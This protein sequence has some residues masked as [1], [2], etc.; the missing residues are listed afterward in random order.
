MKYDFC[1]IGAGLAGLS[2][3]KELSSL[4]NT[5]ILVID[6]LGIGKGASGSPIGLANPATGRYATKSWKAE[7]SLNLL[8]ENLEK[9]SS[10]STEKIFSKSGIV[11]PAMDSKIA[12][13][14]KENVETSDWSDGSCKWL[15]EKE[16]HN[17][18]P[19][20]FCIDGGVW[21]PSGMTV[22]IPKYLDALAS[23]LKVSGVDFIE[24]INFDLRK[25]NNAWFLDLKSTNEIEANHIVITA[26]IKSTR[27][28]FWKDLPLHPVKGQV[29]VFKTEQ[30]FPYRSAISALGYFAG[31]DP[32]TFV[33][34]S[35]YEHKFANEETDRKG[36]SYIEDRMLRVMPYM[37][38]KYKLIQQ[39]AGV[40]ASTPDR[41]PFAGDHP[42]I[43][44]CSILAG[45][46]SKG[47]LY[48]SLL[49]K[50]FAH[51]LLDGIAI[52]P[53]VS[54]NRFN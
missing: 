20:L 28:D 15:S 6:P 21:V 42:H 52:S 12:K 27:Y 31:I 29:A 46:G 33:A 13:R 43:E 4:S 30:K 34:G 26:G 1:I 24:G 37:E 25:S 51:Y 10:F 14:M 38:G 39:W 36:L 48:S 45:L 32:Y 53:E 23:Y 9:V 11:R 50:E 16:L 35:T 54:L 22:A 40:R 2:L 41:K 3:A 7:E 47:L 19:D 49:A 17:N 5:K 44:G 8:E 18:F